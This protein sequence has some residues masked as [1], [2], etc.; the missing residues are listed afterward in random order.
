MKLSQQ[1]L[2]AIEKAIQN[3]TFSVHEAHYMSQHIRQLDDNKPFH[4]ISSNNH[5]LQ[6][7]LLLVNHKKLEIIPL[8]LG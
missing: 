5:F 7:D 2:S 8:D 1:S 6:Y 3:L 4:E